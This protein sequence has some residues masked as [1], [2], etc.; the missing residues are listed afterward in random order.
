MKRFDFYLCTLMCALIY[1][2]SWCAGAAISGMVQ[3]TDTLSFVSGVT[4]TA[5]ISAIEAANTISDGNGN[6]SL[7]VSSGIYT[8]TASKAGYTDAVYASVPAV[9]GIDTKRNITITPVPTGSIAG[10]VR[11]A[12]NGVVVPNAIVELR[13][14]A[15][16]K[17]R[18]A[19]D[20]AGNYS[21][22]V[23]TGPYDAY[24]SAEGY[25]AQERTGI[26]IT[27]NQTTTI[28]I[29]LSP[30]PSSRDQLILNDTVFDGERMAKLPVEWQLTQDIRSCIKIIDSTGVL[31][32]I[33]V[34][35]SCTSGTHLVYWD[36]T[37]EAGA[38]ATSG[39]Y[40]VWLKTGT[41]SSTKKIVLIR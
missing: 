30:Q 33:L 37:N 10:I 38:P 41:T 11:N 9:G 19:T 22:T 36:G 14:F 40:F 27:K 24:V 8:I 25:L 28:N 39:V 12:A 35:E 17:A 7:S 29:A 18:T 32:K 2:P 3:D 1:L 34:D 20:P 5:C 31:I 15:V 13:R 21:M 16:T 4:V 23:T 26:A 6:Y